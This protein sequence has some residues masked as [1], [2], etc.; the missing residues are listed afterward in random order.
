MKTIAHVAAI[1]PDKAAIAAIVLGVTAFS[2]AQGLTYPLIALNLEARGLP[3][4][5]IGLN[6][7]A[8]AAG[9]ATT[10]FLI[11]WLTKR[12][13]GDWLIVLGLLGCSLAL[14]LLWLTHSVLFWLPIRFGLGVAASLV[15]IMSEAWL[16]A[17]TP[18]TLR[19]RV[20]GLYGFGLCLGFAA[21]PLAIPVLGT[22]SSFAF[23]ILAI[24]VA[25]VA[26]ATVVL[27]RRAQTVPAPS[28]AGAL[29]H[30][31]R[32]DPILV[33]MVFAFGF[34]DIAAISGMPVYLIR[35]GQ[36]DTLAALSVSVIA[37]PTAIAQPFVGYL[38]DRVAR[39]RVAIGA[40]LLTALSFL[41][42]PLLE[43]AAGIL[44]DFAL[45]GV[46]SFALYTSAL[47]L[48]GERYSGGLLV[49]G[50]AAFSIAYASGSGA[51]SAAI[52]LAMDTLG[53]AAGPACTG[54]ILLAL[55]GLLLV[56]DPGALPAAPLDAG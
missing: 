14:A 36:S 2:V 22:S 6:G 47:T 30:F 34:A 35:S 19:G 38:L 46:G 25:L 48:L 45:L 3:A 4:W 54:L 42:V 31:L 37:L 11:G 5:Q 26:F 50:S 56:K 52:G 12:V 43:S 17:A 9:L 29:W 32:H 16:N 13:R 27:S 23:G 18:E 24:Y 7:A 10:T 8:F 21:G 44:A 51:G 55:T 15:F 40:S 28:P 53:L 41:C 20:S 33:L 49:A 39:R 1:E